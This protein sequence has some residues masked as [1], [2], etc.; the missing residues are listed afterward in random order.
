MAFIKKHYWQILAFIVPALI[1]AV[2]YAVKGMHPFG[3]K[4]VL[5]TD[6]S[7]QY[8]D[9][10]AGLY[11][12]LKSGE[13]LFYSFRS[14]LG[15]NFVGTYAY[16]LASPLMPII[17][18]FDKANMPDAIML[19][20]LIKIGLCGLFFSIYCRNSVLVKSNGPVALAMS[21]AFA[22]CGYCMVYTTNYMWLDNVALLP[23]VCLGIEALIGRGRFRLLI[24]ALFFC[25][26]SSFYISYMT[27]IFSLMYFLFICARKPMP[28]G[29]FAKRA[30][31]FA[32]TAA[33]A[34]GLAAFLLL[35]T[36][37]VMQ[38][39]YEVS[40][41]F[42]GMA[43]ANKPR[44]LASMLVP[45]AYQ[46]LRGGPPVL[47]IGMLGLLGLPLYFANRKILLR[48]KLF[49]AVIL[50]VLIS[51]HLLK[52]L[53]Y[54]WHTFRYPTWFPGRYAFLF[55]FFTIVLAA[56]GLTI[57]ALPP[58][59]LEISATVFA[60]LLVHFWLSPKNSTK[61]M[62]VVSLGFLCGY[63]VLLF[64]K[65]RGK[66]PALAT[67]LLLGLVVGEQAYTTAIYISRLDREFTYVSHEEYY[68]FVRDVGGV[69]DTLAADEEYPFYRGESK[70][71]RHFNDSMSAGF[72]GMIHFSSVFNPGA[73][74]FTNRL[75]C[76]TYSSTRYAKLYSPC[77][78][79]DALFGVKY[80]VSEE[81]LGQGY[82][83]LE[84][85][86]LPVYKN[87]YAMSLGF[88]VNSGLADYEPTL[89]DLA[90]IEDFF[91]AMTPGGGSVL[92]QAE[93]LTAQPDEEAKVF[94]FTY[95]LQKT[96]QV[97]FSCDSN[98]YHEGRLAVNGVG[99][100]EAHNGKDELR[101]LMNLGFFEAGQ[102]VEIKID[103]TKSDPFVRNTIC[104]TVDED[105]LART[106]TKLT[107]QQLALNKY[108]ETHITGS[109]D[110]LED[111]LLLTTI[112]ADAGWRVRVD[113]KDA[114][115]ITV[116]DALLALPLEAGRHEIEFKYT[117]PGFAQGLAASVVCFVILI[118]LLV[119]KRPCPTRRRN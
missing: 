12:K 19:L 9:F 57:R 39:S 41:G 66:I 88:M 110:V 14:A 49:A 63:F 109:V 102:E 78:V 91:E 71:R 16:Y 81:D 86:G 118:F 89:Y 60:G 30:G 77:V 8:A 50:V 73:N 37:R 23:L 52:P 96:G 108:T 95:R 11:D 54:A 106:T 85:N 90:L 40:V 7:T 58:M 98:I 76:A 69:F 20:I 93:E 5:I 101:G 44:E 72:S 25:F 38:T 59:V 111:G 87:N 6:M 116:A 2:V 103:T 68:G 53:D 43:L 80:I 114:E 61:L 29:F 62:L 84:I 56:R 99:L 21:V 42:P 100:F 107:G 33:L 15:N 36:L 46:S 45:G 83:K 26:F 47:S 112:P 4:S 70:I 35:P 115:T 74:R 113:G 117:P 27:S 32:L 82:E 105:A 31:Q 55:A 119:P 24:A 34:A 48:E 64:I 104:S 65:K 1:L 28:I 92:V 3:D 17:L 18:L 22:L 94:I 10:H 67:L 79:T 51:S 97:Y 75:G 13:S